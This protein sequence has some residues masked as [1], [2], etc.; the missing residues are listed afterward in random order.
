[1]PTPIRELIIQNIKT[2]LESIT[3]SNGY[4][5]DVKEVKRLM[6]VPQ[7]ENAYPVIYIQEGLP[8]GGEEVVTPGR[9]KVLGKTTRILTTKLSFWLRDSNR[10]NRP[11]QAN[12]LL[13]DIHKA[14]TVDVQRGGNAINTSET[15]NILWLEENSDHLAGGKVEFEIEYRH[16]EGDPYSLN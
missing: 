5:F 1:M 11:T 13:A 9:G 7:K 2:T 12:L 10:A 6:N 8:E 16:K 3:T 14:M 4:N 15:A